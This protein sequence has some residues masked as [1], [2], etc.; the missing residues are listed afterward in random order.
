ML[1]SLPYHISCWAACPIRSHD[2][3]NIL[4]Y[5]CY[6]MT[7]TSAIYCSHAYLIIFCCW[8]GL[9][10]LAALPC[11]LTMLLGSCPAD[12]TV[13]QLALLTMLLRHLPCWPCCWATY[14]T[15]HI[16]TQLARLSG[17]LPYWA[18]CQAACLFPARLMHT[19]GWSTWELTFL[20]GSGCMWQVV[21]GSSLLPRT[22]GLV[23]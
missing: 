19:A 13:R 1:G 16:V 5:S 18:Y 21:V 17:S 2:Y 9:F 11:L 12:H 7:A 20:G 22:A 23:Y 4:F 8:G 10:C 14:P 6:Y 15:A 3:S